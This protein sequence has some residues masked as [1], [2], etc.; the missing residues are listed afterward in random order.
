MNRTPPASLREWVLVRNFA[1]EKKRL[2]L[3][4]R[5]DIPRQNACASYQNHRCPPAQSQEP[6][7]GDSTREVGRHYWAEWLREVLA[8][9]RH[10]LCRGTTSLCRESL[11]L[12]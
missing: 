5:F 2:C 3:T 6:R 4:D 8:G 1:G 7:C 12:C 9:F 10:P 11:C